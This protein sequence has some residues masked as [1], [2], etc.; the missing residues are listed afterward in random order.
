MRPRNLAAVAAVLLVFVLSILKS[1]WIADYSQKKADFAQSKNEWVF[2]LFQAS[3]YFYFDDQFKPGVVEFLKA[4]PELRRV[5]IISGNGQAAFDSKDLDVGKTVPYKVD[6]QLAIRPAMPMILSD[7]QGVGVLVPT[8]QYSVYYVFSLA[9]ITMRTLVIFSVGIGLI[10]LLWFVSAYLKIQL[11]TPLTRVFSS[12]LRVYSLRSKFVA[13]I[14]MVNMLTGA[15]I[16]MSQSHVQ[17]REQTE[18]LI[19]NSIL[20]AELSRDHVISSFSNYF[21]FYYN[22]KFVPTIKH[23]IATKENL[24]LIRIISRKSGMVVFDSEEMAA[25]KQPVPGIEGKKAEFGDEI[26][27][28]LKKNET[29]HAV[30]SSGA[31]DPFIQVVTAYRNENGESPFYVEYIFLLRRCEIALP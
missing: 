23:D 13:T 2:N 24:V 17:K 7:P 11:L 20:L 21:Y 30:M 18:R 5:I 19:T 6:P 25:G 9:A 15:I 16:Y 14:V 29:Y 27:N 28:E 4:N 10:A 22:D 1:S 26:L 31:G 3:F 12:T 8:G